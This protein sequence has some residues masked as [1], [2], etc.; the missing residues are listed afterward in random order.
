MEYGWMDGW[1][2]GWRREE[3]EE[4]RLRGPGVKGCHSTRERSWTIDAN[5]T[6]GSVCG[7]RR[8]RVYR[9]NYRDYPSTYIHVQTYNVLAHVPWPIRKK[10]ENRK[11]HPSWLKGSRAQAGAQGRLSA[12]FG[13]PFPVIRSPLPPTSSGPQTLQWA[14]GIPSNGGCRRREGGQ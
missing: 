8:I 5:G 3:A 10:T 1:M 14:Y 7:V 2:D 4:E 6:T 9:D 12:P 11:P 13:S